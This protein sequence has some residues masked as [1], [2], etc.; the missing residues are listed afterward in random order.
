MLDQLHR[1]R[2]RLFHALPPGNLAKLRPALEYVACTRDQV[3]IEAD[4]AL[5]QVYF[6]ES[7]VVSL[8]TIFGDGTAVDMASIGREGCTGVPAVLGAKVSSVRLLTQI[9]GTAMKMSRRAFG[10]ALDTMPAFKA[11]MHDYG[12][13]FLHQAMVSGACNGAHKLSQRLARWLLTT[14]D[15]SDNDSLPIAQHLLA[16]LLGVQ[17]QSVSNALSEMERARLIQNA[18]RQITILDRRGLAEE[19]CECYQRLRDRLSFHLPMTYAAT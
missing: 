17:R 3:L 2:N 15:R 14:H 7:S 1:P 10:W 16:D 13:A 6:P 5:D 9:P 18:R 4:G 12:Q 8:G 11:L 19:S